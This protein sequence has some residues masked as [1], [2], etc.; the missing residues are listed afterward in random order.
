MVQVILC[1]FHW[2][3]KLCPLHNLP[4]FF[5]FFFFNQLICKVSRT[6]KTLNRCNSYVVFL[7]SFICI[8]FHNKIQEYLKVDDNQNY[9]LDI[10]LICR[11]KKKK[12]WMKK[13]LVLTSLDLTTAYILLWKQCWD[14]TLTLKLSKTK[15]IF[16]DKYTKGCFV[17][18]R[19]FQHPPI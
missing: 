16:D 2:G 12:L 6:Q 5:S 14:C 15:Y 9:D 3:D 18:G 4:L 10:F 8:I 7:A 11:Q 19:T 17:R 13:E 1:I